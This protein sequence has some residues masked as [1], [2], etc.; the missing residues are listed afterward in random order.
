M[1][2]EIRSFRIADMMGKEE[3]PS[4]VVAWFIPELGGEQYTIRFQDFDI[5]DGQVFSR[6]IITVYNPSLGLKETLMARGWIVS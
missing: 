3:K 6:A 2:F 4:G 1:S 5:G